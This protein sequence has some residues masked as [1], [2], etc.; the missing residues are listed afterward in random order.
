MLMAVILRRFPF[1]VCSKWTRQSWLASK[2]SPPTLPTALTISNDKKYV[3]KHGD[4]MLWMLDE[5]NMFALS[6]YIDKE[7]K[8]YAMTKRID[9]KVQE[10][11]A[12]KWLD[13]PYWQGRQRADFDP[14]YAE[15]Y[16]DHFYIYSYFRMAFSRFEILD[17]E[18]ST[19]NICHHPLFHVD[20]FGDFFKM[21]GAKR[22]H[23]PL[24]MTF[25][26]C[27]KFA[28]LVGQFAD[29]LANCAL[30]VSLAEDVLRMQRLITVVDGVAEAA[31]CGSSRLVYTVPDSEGKPTKSVH[32]VDLW[33]EASKEQKPY[34]TL[35]NATD[36]HL[37][38]EECSKGCLLSVST[39]RSNQYVF[40]RSQ[41]L[42]R[43]SEVYAVDSRADALHAECVWQRQSGM[44]YTVDHY[45]GHFYALT[46]LS[47]LEEFKVLRRP[48]TDNFSAERNEWT[49]FVDSS[50]E[51][52]IK[53]I[54]FQAGFCVLTMRNS[55]ACPYLH[56]VPLDQ[57]LP[58]CLDQP[59]EYRIM[60]E[61][62]ATSMSLQQN[63]S[64][65]IA[66]LYFQ[67]CGPGLPNTV[68]NANLESGVIRS[69]CLFSLYLESM[70]DGRPAA[71]VRRMFAVCPKD[72][73]QIPITVV[74]LE[75]CSFH[76]MLVN[77]YGDADKPTDMGH[78]RQ[79]YHLLAHKW[80]LAF[81]H[82]RGSHDL[83]RNWFLQGTGAGKEKSFQDLQTCIHF[84]HLAG[85]SR[86][87]HTALYGFGAGGML[88][89]GLAQ[90]QA[91]LFRAAVL[92][93]P[94]VDVLQTY[95]GGDVPAKDEPKLL[96][97]EEVSE[98][99]ER[100]R[101]VASYCPYTNLGEQ[102]YPDMLVTTSRHNPI[103]PVVGV[104][105]YVAKLRSLQEPWVYG[106]DRQQHSVLYLNITESDEHSPAAVR[107]DF[108]EDD[109]SMA[110]AELA[111]L[112]RIV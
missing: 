31:W 51:C 54:F 38:Y 17:K 16:G 98:D 96:D 79:W 32:Y 110:G 86:P 69:T 78:H 91:S 37:L 67:Q 24:H 35:F 82:V 95:T 13:Y 53:S 63:P 6:H 74:Y 83:G 11:I 73:V 81:C 44:E 71:I 21:T 109:K 49:L 72:G 18:A 43:S 102:S 26:P 2:P 23:V 64:S 59:Y 100:L 19:F 36:G 1:G 8:Y 48:D 94:F 87:D 84:L 10:Y 15:E 50:K 39:S 33:E 9:V 106:D 41:T 62:L 56:I 12:T 52:F 30:I 68:T 57:E 27:G 92:Q 34:R 88:V 111:F 4:S 42:Q 90:R 77:V 97:G 66:R 45:R 28:M 55:E 76:R 20:D 7:R 22:L 101:S 80:V 104:V 60:P 75:G 103:V 99:E 58:E 3:D 93:S 70:K 47:Q 65:D 14:E 112:D 29:G 5:R 46:N 108:A 85:F 61:P 107:T 105:R 25:S 89:A 40:I